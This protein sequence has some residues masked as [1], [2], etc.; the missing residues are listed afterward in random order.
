MDNFN[1]S[2]QI[3]M[4]SS[5]SNSLKGEVKAA[6]K[7]IHKVSKMFFTWSMC[8]ADSTLLRVQF[9]L[10]GGN[11]IEDLHQILVWQTLTVVDAS[12]VLDEVVDGHSDL[13]ALRMLVGVQH[14][15][16]ES[17][18]I[19]SIGIGK[20][21]RVTLGVLFSKL[22]HVTIN[23]LSFTWQSEPLEKRSHGIDEESVVELHAV[24]IGMHDS[25]V[26][27]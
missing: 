21:A 6:K 19:R 16:R 25:N 5:S 20:H 17:Q 14:D 12:V 4:V 27:F 7:D 22:Q 26:L 9:D 13:D 18:N 23:L 8:V 1:P 3:L 15:Y 10:V 11:F 24:N 2:R